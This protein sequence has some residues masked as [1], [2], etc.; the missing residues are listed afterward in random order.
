MGVFE[1]GKGY[2]A[3]AEGVVLTADGLEG[4]TGDETEEFD[5][6][7]GSPNEIGRR[8][9]CFEWNV[10]D[11][12]YKCLFCEEPFIVRTQLQHHHHHHYH[13]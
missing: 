6:G 5:D 11:D 7:V 13:A 1:V 9:G 8:R 10:F 12:C 4:V 2:G 3:V